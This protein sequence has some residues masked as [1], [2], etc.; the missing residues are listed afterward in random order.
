MI[1]SMK[2]RCRADLL[3][4]VVDEDDNIVALWEKIMVLDA[5]YGMSWAWSP[6][7]LTTLV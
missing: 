5:I 2:R 1:A 4:A 7:S 3:R 6:M